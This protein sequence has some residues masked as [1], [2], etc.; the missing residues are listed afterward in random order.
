MQFTTLATVSAVAATALAAY[1]NG[2]TVTE[3][4]T[5]TGYT[6]YC[7][8]STQITL[9][10]CDESS[11]APTVITVSEETTLTITEPCVVPTTYTT[12]VNTETV[13]ESCTECEKTTA[14]STV[15]ST[16]VAASTA[17]SVS[18]FEGAAA[19]NA[20]GVVAGVAAIAAALF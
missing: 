1:S 7:P 11:C 20:A 5:V 3:D 2:T 9:T 15:A 6:T 12:Q 4:V 18:S 13:T 16:S 8:E 14:A 10:V 19:K 17:A